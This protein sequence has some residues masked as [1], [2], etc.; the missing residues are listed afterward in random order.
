M[1]QCRKLGQACMGSF[2][3]KFQLQQMGKSLCE[4]LRENHTGSRLSGLHSFYQVMSTPY[5]NDASKWAGIWIGITTRIHRN[6]ENIQNLHLEMLIC[7]PNFSCSLS[8][9][10]A[11]CEKNTGVDSRDHLMWNIGNDPRYPMVRE[12]NEKAISKP[13]LALFYL[14]VCSLVCLNWKRFTRN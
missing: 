9:N 12:T 14:A 11:M 6:P 2:G 10:A 1:E 13:R 5:L 4:S 8:K 7:L 3:S